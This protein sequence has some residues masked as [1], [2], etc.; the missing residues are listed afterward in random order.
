MSP[1]GG[2][3]S[4]VT[5]HPGADEVIGWHPTNGK[6]LFRSSRE[7]HSRFTRLYLIAPDGSGLEAVPLH[8]AGWGSFSQDG[9]RIAYTRVATEDRTWKRYRGGLAPDILA[10]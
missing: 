10:P 5:W 3:I 6:I 9:A 1:D 7:A 2:D 8:E 4:R